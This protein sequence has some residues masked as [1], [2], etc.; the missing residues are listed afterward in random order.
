MKPKKSIEAAK[1]DGAAKAEQTSP[2]SQ[3]IAPGR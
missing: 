3:G 1:S 2:D